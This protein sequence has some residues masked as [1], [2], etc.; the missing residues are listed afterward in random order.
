MSSESFIVSHQIGKIILS[1]DYKLERNPR[2]VA[3]KPHER[4]M[5]DERKDKKGEI[6]DVR[7][8]INTSD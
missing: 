8:G 2:R 1:I 5:W 3:D 7:L 6:K 4:I